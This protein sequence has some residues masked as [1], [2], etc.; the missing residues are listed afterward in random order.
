MLSAAVLALGATPLAY[1]GIQQPAGS[2]I[3]AVVFLT[4]A[5]GALNGYYGLVYSSIQDIVAP[6]LRGRAMGVYF[7]AVYMCGASFGP[8]LT[9][10]LSDRMARRAAEA[11]GRS[12]DRQA[13]LVRAAGYRDQYYGQLANERLGRPL[14][15]PPPIVPQPIDPA[16]RAAFY[17]REVV[18]AAQ[19]LGT[20]GDWQDQTAFVRQIALDAKS[21]SDHVLADELSSRGHGEYSESRG[22]LDRRSRDGDG[23]RTRS[24]AGGHAI[25][26][27]PDEA[28]AVPGVQ[29]DS[30]ALED[31]DERLVARIVARGRTRVDVEPEIDQLFWG[32]VL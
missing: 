21:D 29:L 10:N 25:T 8:L 4:L 11:A 17:A 9:G 14:V 3:A 27:S 2:I 15:A 16:V 22:G 18:Q 19:F 13:Y 30:P 26:R 12:A 20:I 1:V 5:Y 6:A 7:M 28:H 32:S 23:E 24:E 31:A